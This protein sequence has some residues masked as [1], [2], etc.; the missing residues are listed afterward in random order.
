MLEHL[1]ARLYRYQRVDA[2]RTPTGGKQANGIRVGSEVGWHNLYSEVPGVSGA[3][4]TRL[5]HATITSKI[6]GLPT[7]PCSNGYTLMCDFVF[8]R[9]MIY[10]YTRELIAACRFNEY[11][12]MHL[13]G[14]LPSR[15]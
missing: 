13:T 7:P 6:D 15:R 10:K 11:H 2:V 12:G 5:K 1:Q 4:Q 8:F 14:C 9:V 3:E